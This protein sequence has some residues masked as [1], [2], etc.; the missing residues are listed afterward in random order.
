MSFKE[1]LYGLLALLGLVLTWAFNLQFLLSAPDPSFI[2]FFRAGYANWAST[3]LTNDVII[4]YLS[5][6][7]WVFAESARLQLKRAWIYPLLGALVALAFA[8]PLFL[9]LRERHLRNTA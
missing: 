2:G 7:V 5:F 4:C 9:L 8:F 3:S 6:C 1:G